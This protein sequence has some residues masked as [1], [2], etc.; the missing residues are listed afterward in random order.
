MINLVAR[1]LN[2]VQQQF[3]GF[4]R[5]NYGVDVALGSRHIRI[6]KTL[7]VFLHLY[8]AHLIG[9]LCFL[10]L[11]FED[12][13]GSTFGTHNGN[14]GSRPGKHEVGTQVATVHGNI[15]TTI[16]LTQNHGNLGYTGFRI[17]VKHFGAVTNHSRM[18]LIHP[19]QITGHVFQGNDR[20]IKSVTVANEASGLVRAVAVEHT[21]QHQRLVGYKT[22]GLSIHTAKTNDNVGCKKLLNFK[23][24]GIVHNGFN[25]V[26]NIVRLLRIGGNNVL[27]LSVKLR[28]FRRKDLGLLGIVPGYEGDEFLNLLETLQLTTGKE[29][30]IS[31]N[32]GVHTGTTQLFHRNLLTQNG[33]NDVGSGNEHLGDLINHK[34]KVGECRS[35]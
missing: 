22:S 25:D 1:N 28:L 10:N 9:I 26:A 20:N 12:D 14:F 16:G 5:L 7:N 4:L 27:D 30:C 32:F 19:G 6:G 35:E 33:L 29:M 34:H 3:A 21:G 23:E 31:G 24:I 15:T 13:V 18:L 17:G 2:G 11:L 8:F